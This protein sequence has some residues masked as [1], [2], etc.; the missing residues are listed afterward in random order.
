MAKRFLEERCFL[1][2]SMCKECNEFAGQSGDGEGL[3]SRCFSLWGGSKVDFTY[4]KNVM[5][6]K[7]HTDMLRARSDIL[8]IKSERDSDRE[9]IAALTLLF[10]SKQPLSLQRIIDIMK[11]KHKRPIFLAK[12]IFSLLVFLSNEFES[13]NEGFN[14][15]IQCILAQHVIDVYNL[16]FLLNN[17]GHH[18][19]EV[20]ECYFIPRAPIIE[21]H[22]PFVNMRTLHLDC[23]HLNDRNV[24]FYSK[25]GN[26]ANYRY[27]KTTLL[28]LAKKYDLP[29]DM[30][31][32]IMK[33]I[34]ISSWVL[35]RFERIKNSM[36]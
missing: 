30:K 32:K 16:R 11:S 10:T 7:R 29:K 4:S 28:I 31:K 5:K 35:D 20:M 12:D 24:I 8:C 9:I 17:Y 23:Y 3:C 26:P 27:A 33:L 1:G 19:D 14:T 15:T 36:E 34:N 18:L 21:K 25:R 13:D 6:E 2:A 22:T